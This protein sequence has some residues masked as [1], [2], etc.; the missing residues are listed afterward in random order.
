MRIHGCRTKTRG[1][2]RQG[3]STDPIFHIVDS[4]DVAL[5]RMDM[6]TLGGTAI[7]G[8]GSKPGLLDELEIA[9]NRILACQS[10]IRV[11]GGNNITIHHNR[12]RMLDKQGSDVAIYIAADDSLIERND[13]RLVPAPQ[14][15]P[16][17]MPDQPEPT[18]PND[19]CAK[20]EIVYVNPRIF[21]KYIDQVWLLP[22]PLLPKLVKPYRART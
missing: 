1:V 3:A 12:I 7:F 18:D 19:P 14:M 6:V 9:D 8:E 17:K 20:F 11:E 5:E 2:P 10:A 22:L 4:T 13:V 16:I 21:T 15:P